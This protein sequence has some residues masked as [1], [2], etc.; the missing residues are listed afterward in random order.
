M[1]LNG[2]E[3]RNFFEIVIGEK[4]V[5]S[6]S[7]N[8]VSIPHYQRPYRWTT[9]L[10]ANLIQDWAQADSDYF[11]GSIVTVVRDDS[12]IFELIDGQQRLTTIYLDY[13]I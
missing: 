5:D 2:A 7:R 12:K 1:E 10:V 4:S 9:D 11:A 3:I 13:F 6:K 8:I